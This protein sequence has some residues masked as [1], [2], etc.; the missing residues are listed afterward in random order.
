MIE[1][2][3]PQAEAIAAVYNASAFCDQHL[4]DMAYDKKHMFYQR[5]RTRLLKKILENHPAI[6]YPDGTITIDG[7]R[8]LP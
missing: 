3:L 7:W 8:V 1:K 5:I 4:S 6:E 2:A